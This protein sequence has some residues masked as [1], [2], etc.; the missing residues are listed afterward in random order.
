MLYSDNKQKYT[1]YTADDFLLDTFFIQSIK[2]PTAETESF[3]LEFV[4]SKPANLNEFIQAK[5]ILNTIKDDERLMLT[6]TEINDILRSIMDTNQSTKKKSKKAIRYYIVAA[7]IA[8]CIAIVFMILPKP[9]Q[10]HGSEIL[11]YIAKKET[12]N[13]NDTIVKLILSDQK[14]IISEEAEPVIEYNKE[15]IKLQEKGI[16]KTESA[17]YNQLI[18]PYGKR[19]RLTLADGTKLWVNAGTTLTYP[20]EFTDERREIYVNGEVFLDVAPDPEH[21]FIVKTNNM[22]IEVL[23]TKFNVTTYENEA[24]QVVL[25]SGAVQIGMSDKNKAVNLVPNDIFQLRDGEFFKKQGDVEYYTSWVNGIYMFENEKLDVVMKRLSRY[26]GVPI[27]CEAGIADFPPCSGK[28]DL[29]D[30]LDEIL[31]GLSIISSIKYSSDNQ[32]YKIY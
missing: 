31:E 2:E 6:E 30:N 27:E 14:I 10:I 18:V 24:N 19:S 9:D 5:E 13:F 28:L 11:S 4:D 3:W 16:A 29:K 17:K 22:D 25:V 12:V 23:G 21:P 1:T 8:A 32:H 20:I 26:Y 15:E 7:S